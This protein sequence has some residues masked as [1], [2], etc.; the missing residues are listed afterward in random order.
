MK[1]KIPRIESV[2]ARD[3]AGYGVMGRKQRRRSVE[4]KRRIVEETLVSGA[5]VAAVARRHEANAN[6]VF[7]WRREYQTGKL[8]RGT[9]IAE[10][11]PVGVVDKSSILRP[12]EPEPPVPEPPAR[13]RRGKALA[14]TGCWSLEVEL[15]NGVKVRVGGGVFDEKDMRRVLSLARELA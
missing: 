15:P 7:M 9:A 13:R 12:V 1:P 5:S 11:V 8:G 10:F 4:E 6:Q 2:S 3:Q 14:T